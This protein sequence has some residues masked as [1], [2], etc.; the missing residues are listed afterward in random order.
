[1]AYAECCFATCAA[2]AMV[3]QCFSYMLTLRRYALAAMM[4]TCLYA[5]HMRSFVITQYIYRQD[6]RYGN[7]Y[8]IHFAT[9]HLRHA[10]VAVAPMPVML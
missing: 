10:I 4:I 2:A 9:R 5:A 8:F 3:Q 1:M 7:D 6:I